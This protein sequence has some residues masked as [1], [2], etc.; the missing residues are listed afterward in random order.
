MN[1]K[2]QNFKNKLV[3]GAIVGSVAAS[4]AFADVTLSENGSVT[5]TLSTA[6]FM[7]VAGLVITALAVIWAAKKG[8]SLL[9]S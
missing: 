7:G 1:T 4:S 8:I 5:G 2:I 6:T 9:R 3:A